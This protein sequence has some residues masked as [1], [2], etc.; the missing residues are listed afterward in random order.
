MQ[1]HF[2]DNDIPDDALRLYEAAVA[3]AD[4]T[5]SFYVGN[6]VAWYGQAIDP[7]ADVQSVPSP[8]GR[9]R[10]L[11]MTALRRKGPLTRRVT[12]LSLVSILEGVDL[13]DLIDLDVQGYEAEVLEAAADE[14]D[15]K[16]KRVHIGTHSVENEER[17]RGLFGRLG[18]IKR[19]DFAVAGAANTEYGEIVF[20][21]GVQ[22][23]INP[24]ID[25]ST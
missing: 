5:V 6:A 16:V 15:A 8:G 25:R 23:W 10:S 20:Q 2:R 11:A 22:T 17:C 3:S 4:G 24:R 9:L 1:E 12:A 21:D 19:N 7:Y 13:V 18:W 14:L